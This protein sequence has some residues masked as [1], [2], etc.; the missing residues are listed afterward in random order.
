MAGS[1]YLLG[2]FTFQLLNLVLRSFLL[3]LILIIRPLIFQI[4][5]Q[6]TTPSA[7]PIPLSIL[8]DL[9]DKDSHDQYGPEQ[10]D[11]QQ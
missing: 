3:W 5:S 1:N 11:T 8:E 4:S 7:K 10:I 9:P 6:S 2:L